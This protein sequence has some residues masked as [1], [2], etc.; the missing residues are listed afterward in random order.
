MAIRLGVDTGGTYTDAVLMQDEDRVIAKAKALTT[1][2][3]LAVG[4]RQ[5][6]E[7]VLRSSGIAAEAIKL[8]ALS[9][10]LA[11]NAL[12][13]G[14]GGR[15]ALIFVGFAER[16]LD[17]QGLRTALAGDPYLVLDGGHDHSGQPRLPLDEATLV[18]FLE[19]RRDAVSAFAV[20]A[21]FAVRNPAHEQRV[22]ELVTEIAGKPVSLS[23]HLSAKLGGP[24]RALT[25]VLNARLIGMI[26]QLITRA[27]MQIGDL[28]VTA[29]LLVVRGDGALVSAAQARQTPIETILSGPAASLV[30]ARWLTGLDS[31]LVSDIGGTTTDVAFLRQGRPA[32]DA[33][34]AVVG[35]H[36]TMVEAVAMRTTGLGGDSEVT[37]RQEGLAGGVTL[38]PQRVVPGSL[39]GQQRPERVHEVLDRQLRATTPGEFDGQFL[40]AVPGGQGT[41][42][43]DREQRLLDRIGD[44][45]VEL[46]QV[47]RTRVEHSALR[48]LIRQG[49]VQM[50]GVTPS[51]A[52]HVLGWV[53]AWDVAA[54]EKALKLFARRRTGSGERL[55]ET[56]VEMAR[57]IVDQ[58]TH[59][60][61]LAMLEAAFAEEG[62]SFEAPPQTLARHEVVQA[63]LNRHRCH[64]RVDIGLNVPVIGLGASAHSYYPAVGQRLGTEMVLPE[65]ADV[66]NAI[67]AVVGQI[68]V[69]RS[70][71]VSA[72]SEGRFRAHLL[73]GPQDFATAEAALAA[74]EAAL[75]TT[76]IA[77]ARE[78]GADTPTS[79]LTRD[80]RKVQVENREIFVEATVT[81]EASGRPRIAAEPAGMSAETTL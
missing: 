42:L 40:R 49:A 41:G 74:L 51:D 71:T 81:A 17:S 58:M 8:A 35:G 70:G 31:A 69:R 38:G 28:G 12:V 79:S 16:D 75:R 67:G 65:D 39:V 6:I 45:V 27:Q 61:S 72:P 32:L 4:V 48:R 11:T 15:V 7:A 1:R 14:H 63:G 26:D 33:R 34:G 29:P 37:P 5:A 2:H 54:G 9:T 50:C 44:D 66:A 23:H 73:S 60:S 77:L 43:P 68:H 47:L 80:I 19:A 36:R 22:Q 30:G 55:A 18:Q 20:A 24:K 3:D 56:P 13:E 10:T 21:Q 25:A 62:S 46:G 76:V 78:A 57:M 52:A 64:L 59:Q 53:R